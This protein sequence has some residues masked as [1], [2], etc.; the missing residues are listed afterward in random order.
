MEAQKAKL[1]RGHL[2]FDKVNNTATSKLFVSLLQRNGLETDKFA[3]ATGTLPGFEWK[4]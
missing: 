1:A 2:A 3:G 4:A